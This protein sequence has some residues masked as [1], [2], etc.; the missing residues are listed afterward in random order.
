MGEGD[1]TVPYEFGW[2]F[3]NL[4]IDDVGIAFDVD[5]GVDGNLAQSHVTTV[6]SALG[7]FQ[8]GFSAFQLSGACEDVNPLLTDTGNVPT[9]E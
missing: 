1:L 5:F 7:R 6:M 9:L 2:G 4:N 8:V 3:M